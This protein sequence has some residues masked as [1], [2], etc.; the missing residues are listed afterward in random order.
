MQYIPG[1]F[2]DSS[3]LSYAC[4]SL[5]SPKMSRIPVP[6]EF[7]DHFAAKGQLEFPPVKK[8]TDPKIGDESR[9]GLVDFDFWTPK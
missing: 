3:K 6:S 9:I 8:K 7:D 1:I 5:A 4:I 2:Q